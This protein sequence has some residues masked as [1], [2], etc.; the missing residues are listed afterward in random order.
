MKVESILPIASFL[1]RTWSDN[2]RLEVKLEKN[3]IP[4]CYKDKGLVIV[5]L[6]E[7]YKCSVPIYNYR[8]WRVSLWHEA[9]HMKHSPLLHG[10]NTAIHQAIEDYRIGYIGVR[11]YPG[12]KNE[13]EFANAMHYYVIS[14]AKTNVDAFIQKLLLGTVKLDDEISKD[15]DMNKVDEAVN[16]TITQL[17]KYN[18]CNDPEV[19]RNIA[20]EVA[21]IL[22]VDLNDYTIRMPTKSQPHNLNFGFQ[23]IKQEDIKDAV[24]Q[25]ISKKM[26]KINNKS[27]VSKNESANESSEEGKS[28]EDAKTSNDKISNDKSSNEGTV[29]NF[30]GDSN[31]DIEAKIQQLLKPGEDVEKEFTVLKQIE[32]Q[33]EKRDMEGVHIPRRLHVE[34]RYLYDQQLIKH[35]VSVFSRLR[36]G[37]MEYSSTHGEFDVEN[38]LTTT[39]PF[40]DEKRMK[41][42]T[43]KII[44]LLD[45]SKSIDSHNPYKYKTVCVSIAEALNKLGI[46][47]AVYAFNTTARCRP[48]P[49]AEIILWQ[50]KGEREPWSKMNARRLAQIQTQ[51]ATP[52][53]EIYERLEKLITIGSNENIIMFTITD[54]EPTDAYGHSTPIIE[55]ETAKVIQRLKK[56]CKMYAIAI[57]KTMY[58]AVNLA[59]NLR[60]L[61]YDK[62]VATDDLKKLPMKVLK[63]IQEE[64][65]GE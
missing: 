32:K 60:G 34:E 52:M 54:G 5:G 35:L 50:I 59:N 25:Y 14:P 13:R 26:D 49:D 18:Y 6:P 64:V 62:Y 44:L 31:T 16:Y 4:R 12:M 51:G 58:D 1:A 38:Y 3:T 63:M 33:E 36:R 10:Y 28:N 39:K 48:T 43:I 9:M 19:V 21:R 42:K 53:K 55:K 56:H 65:M 24:K 23:K 29:S 47:F 22:D 8:L 40:I 11:E 7:D 41:R 37:W 2:S 46:K 27:N 30:I 17:E 57:G 61:G 15:V 45:L 20:K